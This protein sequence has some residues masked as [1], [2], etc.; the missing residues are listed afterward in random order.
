MAHELIC[1]D[2]VFSRDHTA[3][4]AA[5]THTRK[6]LPFLYHTY[7]VLVLLQICSYLIFDLIPL[8]CKCA[9][10]C[11]RVEPSPAGR[12]EGHACTAG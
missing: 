10:V 6:H 12:G 5:G 11:V 9:C 1:R 4:A 8:V 2:Y 7:S 3:H